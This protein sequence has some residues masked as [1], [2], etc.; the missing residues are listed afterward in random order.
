MV[1]SS[2]KRWLNK[3][4]TLL[5]CIFC[6][7]TLPDVTGIRRVWPLH[8]VAL[9][10]RLLPHLYRGTITFHNAEV[11]EAWSDQPDSHTVA[12][13]LFCKQPVKVCRRLLLL[14]KCLRSTRVVNITNSTAA[15][16]SCR[17]RIPEDVLLQ[18]CLVV[19]TAGLVSSALLPS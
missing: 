18:L 13:E 4:G 14:I 19:L 2:G 3:A 9:R 10:F 17:Q 11:V 15:T 8:A 6:N 1:V 7:R 12:H 16:K 5:N